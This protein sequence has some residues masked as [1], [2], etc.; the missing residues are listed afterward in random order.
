M[1]YG[2]AMVAVSHEKYSYEIQIGKSGRFP[3]KD[4]T[5]F[6]AK[7]LLL[8]VFFMLFYCLQLSFYITIHLIY[9]IKK[10]IIPFRKTQKKTIYF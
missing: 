4:K 9:L 3:K 10:D 7:R 5:S 1:V 8:A 6:G 2:L